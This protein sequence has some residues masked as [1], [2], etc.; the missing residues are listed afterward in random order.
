MAQAYVNMIQN[1]PFQGYTMKEL[2]EFARSVNIK[3]YKLRKEEL[4]VALEKTNPSVS[5]INTKKIEVEN[6][7]HKI[8][9]FK[10]G[11]VCKYSKKRRNIPKWMK[12]IIEGTPATSVHNE[13]KVIVNTISSH[14]DLTPLNTIE[15]LLNDDL[16][17]SDSDDDDVKM[18]D[19][20]NFD[21][22][23]LVREAMQEIEK[24]ENEERVPSH[25]LT[26]DSSFSS[27]SDSNEKKL[28]VEIPPLDL[29]DDSD[30][31]SNDNVY[32]GGGNGLKYINI[33]N[34]SSRFIKKFR[35]HIKNY[36]ISLKKNLKNIG[37]LDLVTQA[38]DEMVSYTKKETNF[39]NGD[40]LRI[41]IENPQFMF[42]I[43]T[44]YECKDHVNKLKEKVE[45][46]L[47]SNEKI[48]IEECIFQIHVV[49]MPRGA[50][51]SRRILNLDK[52]R[53]TKKC[54]TQIRNN[55]N[56]CCPRAV[57][58]GLTYYSNIILD[59]EM[60]Q[61]NIRAI[62]QGW[63]LQTELA[64]ELCNQLGDYT[65]EGFTLEDIRNLEKLLDIQI[66]IIDAEDLNR[67][68][69]KGED[70]DVIIH[71]YKQGNHFDLISSMTAFFGSS[72]YCVKCDKP[73]ST[74]MKKS[75]KCKIEKK[76]CPLCMKE[77]HSPESV[78]KIYCTECN[79][80]CCNNQCLLDHETDTCLVVFKCKMCSKLVQRS[81]T[82][83]HKC[84]Y[85]KC[86]NCGQVV[87]IAVH[88]CFMMNRKAKGGRCNVKNCC[89]C[90]VHIP[91]PCIVDDTD[92]KRIVGK[93]Y[94]QL[95]LKIHPDK[96]GNEEQQKI[97]NIAYKKIV[98]ILR[99]NPTL[100]S[101][102]FHKNE[103]IF[104]ELD[105]ECYCGCDFEPPVVNKN[106]TYLE[107]YI[108]FD[109]E[110]QQETGVHIPNLV[111]VHW[112]IFSRRYGG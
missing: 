57:I 31:E 49:N 51:N 55:D 72:Y 44:G 10:L 2:R 63:R 83:E 6:K 48:N 16:Y 87:E 18:V 54:I 37:K 106:C 14:I 97:L 74:D 58:V 19:N 79:R 111:V 28:L 105:I 71:L 102:K 85:E 66:K 52:D 23:T 29:S 93:N 81:C 77:E 73:L 53:R 90:D 20:E 64:R 39:Q 21:W 15:E 5:V 32:F 42:P 62:R 84:G 70:K 86:K 80:Y 9:P 30:L 8:F 99:N 108:F 109:Y 22:E 56:L 33:E 67:I 92:V 103:N 11:V 65:E 35:S 112:C 43:F 60:T 91:T 40:K 26:D 104:R 88:K 17:L 59:R 38:L 98:D 82:Y 1:S 78:K 107:K 75:H 96:G 69:Y 7:L 25:N 45:Q 46:I 50:S 68:M 94:R 27:D 3:Y 34:I 47:S 110:C 36:K 100:S 12:K 41:I 24:E 13:Q 4:V 76:V 61:A 89:N 101:K 95:S